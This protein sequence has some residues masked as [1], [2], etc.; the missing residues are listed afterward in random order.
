MIQKGLQVGAAIVLLGMALPQTAAAETLERAADLV[1][2]AIEEHRLFQTC[3]S[4]LPREPAMVSD[5]WTLLA[6]DALEVLSIHP[7]T[8]SISATLRAALEPGALVPSA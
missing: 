8:E 2:N 7:G 6:N 5:I 1:E 4:L 3:M